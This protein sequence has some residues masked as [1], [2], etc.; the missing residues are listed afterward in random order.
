MLFLCVMIRATAIKT[1]K[2]LNNSEGV[3][4]SVKSNIGKAMPALIE[5]TDIMRVNSKII[6]KTTRHE[7]VS[8]G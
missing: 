1:E 8:S 3:S 7:S 5:D 2:N 6:R 4:K